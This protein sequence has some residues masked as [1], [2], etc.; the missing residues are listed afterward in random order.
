MIYPTLIE[1]YCET[2][3][4]L[5]WS[6]S[7]YCRYI[8]YNLQNLQQTLV[9]IGPI[10][11]PGCVHLTNENAAQICKM[12]PH[13]VLFSCLDLAPTLAPGPELLTLCNERR[14]LIRNTDTE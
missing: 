9:S 6:W 8:C 1:L 12:C 11:G 4:L 2:A 5:W 13:L 3:P 7:F 14:A 10:R